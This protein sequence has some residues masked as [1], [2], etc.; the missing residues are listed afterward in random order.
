MTFVKTFT[1]WS[2]ENFVDEEI[3]DFLE[4]SKIDIFRESFW[5]SSLAFF[6]W[7]LWKLFLTGTQSTTRYNLSLTV[8][9]SLTTT[10]VGKLF[11][12]KDDKEIWFKRK[13]WCLESWKYV[14]SFSKKWR[15]HLRILSRKV[16]F[17]ERT[18]KAQRTTL[19][20]IKPRDQKVS[21]L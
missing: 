21:K 7:K 2:F 4:M 13:W 20:S 17:R 1:H 6:K 14:V 5:N 12:F 11:I 3:L 8:N 10:E 9:W 15:F 18:T 19:L 16:K